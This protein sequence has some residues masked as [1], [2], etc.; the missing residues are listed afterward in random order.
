MG[1][2]FLKSKTIDTN[3]NFDN[4]FIY[5]PFAG[6]HSHKLDNQKEQPRDIITFF[7]TRF[8]YPKFFYN[9]FLS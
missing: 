8:F 1:T 4:T 7:E 5:S 9:F 6:G 3:I 2:V